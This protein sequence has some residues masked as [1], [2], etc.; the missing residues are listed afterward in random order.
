M[1]DLA[2]WK[3]SCAIHLC[4][5]LRYISD[6]Q[7]GS[8]HWRTKKLSCIVKLCL[9]PCAGGLHYSLGRNTIMSLIGWII[10]QII[11][12]VCIQLFIEYYWIT[13]LEVYLITM[14]Y[15]YVS[16]S[17]MLKAWQLK[18]QNY[19]DLRGLLCLSL[20]N[21]IFIYWSVYCTFE[22]FYLHSTLIDC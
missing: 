3:G 9:V 19:S 11:R 18:R 21:L 15:I 2:L 5:L 6:V 4:K 1:E 22:F 7:A 20:F 8:G 17:E 12:W 13:G 14:F 10:Y 16:V